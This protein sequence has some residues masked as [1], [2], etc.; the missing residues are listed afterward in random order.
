MAGTGFFGRLRGH[1]LDG[2]SS[3]SWGPIALARVALPS[4]DS[5]PL[6][7]VTVPSMTA[8]FH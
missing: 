2:A 5:R 7:T 3:R 6:V 4:F 8:P 1:R